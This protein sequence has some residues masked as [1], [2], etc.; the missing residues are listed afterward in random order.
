LEPARR[1]FNET[2]RYPARLRIVE[3]TI[4]P[5]RDGIGRLGRIRFDVELCVPR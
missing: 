2:P 3:S 5:T 1:A 4:T